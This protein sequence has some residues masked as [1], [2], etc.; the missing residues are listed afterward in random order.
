MKVL[1]VSNNPFSKY[2]NNGKT[3]EALFSWL[4]KN[5][6]AQLYFHSSFKPDL[7]FCD[8]YYCL[9]DKDILFS[10]FS[11]RQYGA[12]ISKEDSFENE[13]RKKLLFYSLDLSVF[14]LFRDYLWKIG[15]K[16]SKTQKLYNWIENFAP[17]ILFFVGGNCG[18]SHYV[19]TDIIQKYNLRL[20]SYFTDDYIIYP[21]YK[22]VL[23]CIQKKRLEDIYEKTICLSDICFVIG[24]D[25]AKAY[26][27]KYAKMFIPI[28][29]SVIIEEYPNPLEKDEIVI[30]YFGNLGI[31][32]WQMIEK[33]A[34]EVKYLRNK[35]GLKCKVKVYSA[36]N[37]SKILNSFFEADVCY[38]GFVGGEE[39]K[40]ALVESDILLHVESND[41]VYRS[42]TYL[43]ISTKI[44]E[45]LV[46]KRP[47]LAFGPIEVA[48][49]SLL[50]NNNIGFVINCDD[51]IEN[52]RT[53]LYA[54]ICNVDNVRERV[55][56]SGFD[57]VCNNYDLRKVQ[58][59]FK[60]YFV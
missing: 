56:K 58:S 43:S 47:I 17:D 35:Y 42:V 29:N 26:S 36:D 14:L 52:I 59:E 40:R 15:Y 12:I 21:R 28:M 25:M 60:K 13:E 45:Y 49:I 44:P 20:Y 10:L 11:K 23:K 22:N 34:I 38:E 6:L 54:I 37:K 33:L 16:K 5:N 9:S 19:S 51:S 48:S 53:Q 55:A 46:T 50:K 32:R 27:E 30:S 3:L 57:Y 7:S 1:V 4:P 39:L 24:T 8:N 41:Y 2:F 31:N 18:F